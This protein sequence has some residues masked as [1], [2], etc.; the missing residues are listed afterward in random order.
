MVEGHDG[1]ISFTAVPDDLCEGLPT[2][3]FTGKAT[4]YRIFLPDLFPNLDRILFLDL[5]LIVTDSLQPLWE[6]D[7]Q[8]R[9][10]AAVTNVLP[11]HYAE[12]L[13]SAGFDTSAYFNAGVLLMD[14]DRMRQQG[15]TASML[16]YGISHAESLVLRDQDA[17]NAVLADHRLPLDPRWNC[18]NSFFV[19]PWSED[20]FDS[21]LLARAKSK[22]AIRH[23]EGPATNKPWHYLCEHDSR[24][25]YAEHRKQTPWPRFRSEG[26]TPKNVV[27][28]LKRGLRRTSSAKPTKVRA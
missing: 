14:L 10:V 21:E 20:L 7:L 8:G 11:H 17:L 22:P 27:K 24:H 4:W 12:R 23:F 13:I 18:M 3:G 9:L 19:Y 15:C 25:L 2:E 6:T 16:N 26:T 5:D 1:S 28:R